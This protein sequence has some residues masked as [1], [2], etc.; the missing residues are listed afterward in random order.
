MT[1]SCPILLSSHR[2][3]MHTTMDVNQTR[4]SSDEKAGIEEKCDADVL[5]GEAGAALPAHLRDLYGEDDS[6]VDPVYEAKAKLINDAF[7]EIG[8]GRY[9]VG[10]RRSVVGFVY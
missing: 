4:A 6:G 2:G 8:M 9:Q 5:V 1:Y 10:L 3:E 7:E